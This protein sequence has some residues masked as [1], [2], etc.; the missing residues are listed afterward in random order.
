MPFYSVPVHP[1]QTISRTN[2]TKYPFHTFPF[3]VPSR[4]DFL[5]PIRGFFFFNL[6]Q[7]FSCQRTSI[8]HTLMST[9]IHRPCFC[10]SQP[11]STLITI[12]RNPP[13]CSLPL[14]LVWPVFTFFFLRHLSELSLSDRIP[15]HLFPPCQP[16]NFLSQYPYYTPMLMLRNATQYCT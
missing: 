14:R 10:R 1:N 16:M 9:R 11:D 4:F 5:Q 15:E 13:C 12:C 8:N 3:P 2:I 7:Y 6:Y